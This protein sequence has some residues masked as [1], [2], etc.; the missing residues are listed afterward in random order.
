MFAADF[1]DSDSARLSVRLYDGVKNLQ[2]KLMTVFH[3]RVPVLA[4]IHGKCIGGGIDLTSL[5]DIR[6]C[7]ADAEFSIKEID[8]G[9]AA[10]L[11][12][13]QFFPNIIGN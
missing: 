12:T 8:I 4:G 9:M 5:C 10:D 6:Y 11:G 13:L 3:C 2:Q 1:G 7:T